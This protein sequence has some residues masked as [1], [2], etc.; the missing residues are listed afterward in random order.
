MM[1][2]NSEQHLLCDGFKKYLYKRS[3]AKPV[4][5]FQVRFMCSII[6]FRR[7]EKHC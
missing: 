1:S 7:K 4:F 6:K 5:L 3:Y 2:Y